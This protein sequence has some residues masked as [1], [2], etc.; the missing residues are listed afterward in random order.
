MSKSKLYVLYCKFVTC[1]HLGKINNV[2]IPLEIFLYK[3]SKLFP[4][5]PELFGSLE[6]SSV[7]QDFCVTEG[8]HNLT[9]FKNN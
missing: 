1:L 6:G 4:S 8:V 3:A 5:V 7:Y 2:H 9:K